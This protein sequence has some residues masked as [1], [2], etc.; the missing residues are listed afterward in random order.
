MKRFVA[1]I[2]CMM[3]LCCMLTGCS[4]SPNPLS[5]DMTGTTTAQSAA[6]SDVLV[7]AYNREDT[8]DPFSAKTQL[9]LS[10]ASLLY[11]HLVVPD[12]AFMP[13]SKLATVA[14]SD[15]T[16]I[17]ATLLD[18]TFSDG[19]TVTA[20]DVLY[21]FEQARASEHYKSRLSIFESAAVKGKTITFT[22][23]TADRYAA[24]CLCFPIIKKNTATTDAA[25]APVGSGNYIYNA[26]TATF[27]LR[28]GRESP[29]RTVTL[30]HY[31]NSNAVL[32]ALENGSIQYM[33]N[34]LSDGDIPRTTATAVAV[35][36]PHLVYLGVNSARTLTDSPLYRKALSNALDRTAIVAAA[37]TGRAH[38]AVS[39]FHPAWTPAKDLTCM[40]AGSDAG[41]ASLAQQAL[42]ATTAATTVPTGS[43]TAATAT[44]TTVTTTTT[45]TA[46]TAASGTTVQTT[47]SKDRTLT[48]IYSSGN[49]CRDATVKMIVSQL[50]AA[51]IKAEAVS[52]AYSDYLKRLQAGDYDLYLG[53]IRLH[54]N[55]DL[56]AFLENGNA[57]FGVRASDDLLQKYKAFRDGSGTSAAFVTAFGEELPYIP[58]CW[59][60]GMAAYHT[61]AATITPTA[62]DLFYGL[63]Q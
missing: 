30:R 26:K 28:D 15:A 41:A 18:T 7:L 24:A 52:L 21:S 17:T 55:M 40:H 49:S 19:S 10:L 37:Y 59:R 11:D 1:M 58:I 12:T 45:T 57:S 16:H 35:E 50:A 56:S 2:C 31:A 25:T 54:P 29:V 23:R 46:T 51:G 33:F 5:E 63:T 42:T 27:T 4:S 43:T 32:Q 22:L 34:D 44:T 36:L 60:Q 13:Q 38:A 6:T 9:N 3:S 48:L 14:V 47:I 53:E 8:L 61:S 62:Y 20:A 39:P